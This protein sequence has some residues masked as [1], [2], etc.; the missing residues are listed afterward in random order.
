MQEERIR[1]INFKDCK[2]AYYLKSAIIDG[3]VKYTDFVVAPE[4]AELPKF[5]TFIYATSTRTST[6]TTDIS[7]PRNPRGRK[8]R[9]GK[10]NANIDIHQEVGS[11]K[12]RRNKKAS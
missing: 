10:T 1:C 12:R 2:I 11:S 5:N 8:P 7:K 9:T 6:G 4:P 3:K